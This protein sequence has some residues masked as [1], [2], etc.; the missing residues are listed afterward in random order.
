[1]F[2]K[3]SGAIAVQAFVVSLAAFPVG[4]IAQTPDEPVKLGVLDDMSGPYAENSG[5]G[6]VLAVRM[7]IKDFGGTMFDKP[8]ELVSGDLQNKVDI[9]MAV[10]RKWFDI[11]HVDAILGMGSSGVAIAVQGLALEK[12]KITL[13][14]TPATTELTGKACSPNSVHWVYDTY[15]LAKGAASAVVRQGGKSWYFITA[16]YAFGHALEAN[17]AY[18]VK[19]LGGTVLGAVRHP[20]GS[21]DFSSFLLQAQNSRAQIIGVANAGADTIGVLKQGTEFGITQGGQKMVGLLM[22]VTEIHTLGLDATR[23][24]QFVEAFYWDQ[25]DETRAFSKRFW[26]EYGQPPTQVQA[27]TYSAAMHY[28]KAVQAVG[29]KDT[30]SIMAKMRETPINDFMTKNGKIR[31]DG[32]V[33][34]DMYLLETKTKEESKGEWD[35]MKIVATIPGEDAFRPLSESECPLVIKQTSGVR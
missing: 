30:K 34:R 17:A 19:A 27:G 8:I 3:W 22:Q 7:A 35:L 21:A 15:S 33:I 20:T 28:L 31:E 6:N 18:F 4:A 32:R 11:E 16:D 13:S 23:G 25:N 29:N 10:A 14:T 9:G 24:L 5:Q 1:M 2:R 26:Q 12:N